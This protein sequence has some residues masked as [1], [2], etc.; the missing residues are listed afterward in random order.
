[1]VDDGGYKRHPDSPLLG[2]NDEQRLLPHPIRLER[3]NKV[4]EL[5]VKVSEH[6][7][8]VRAGGGVARLGG[9]V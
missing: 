9:G 7:S 5:R 8:D 4:R 6:G 1:M 3:P 2:R